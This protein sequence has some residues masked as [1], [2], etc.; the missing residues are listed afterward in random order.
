MTPPA[1]PRRLPWLRPRLSIRS[2]MVLVLLIAAPASWVAYQIRIQREAI[3]TVR[4]AGGTVTF[5]YQRDQVGTNKGGGPVN[6]TEP[7]APRWL[8]RLLGDELFQ[9]VQT[10]RFP[11]PIT[12]TV[13]AAVGR[14]AGLEDLTL[15]EATGAE[16]GFRHL[17]GLGRLERVMIGGPGI[18]D[19]MLDDLAQVAAIR[20]LLLG[21]PQA[22][23]ADGSDITSPATDA[24]FARLAVLLYLEALTIVNFPA[25]T[26]EGAARLLAGLP[27]LRRF[28]LGGVTRASSARLTLE[29]LADHHPGLESL[30]LNYHTGIGEADLQAVGK[31]RN[32]Q[33]LNLAGTGIT[34]A[35][36]AHLRPLKGLTILSFSHTG[37]TDAGLP[38]LGELTSLQSLTL[39]QTKVTDAGII[40]LAPLANLRKLA[41]DADGITD[42][43]MPAVARLGK[44]EDLHLDL[45]PGLTDA[46]LVPLRALAK[47]KVLTV[48]G[49]STTPRGIAALRQAV[50]T[51]TRVNSKPPRPVP[52]PPTAK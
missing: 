10:V 11:K 38:T 25:L 36:L 17:R 37:V 4:A 45:L 6:R 50:P 15:A 52:P 49:T 26:D 7:A 8:R 1:L 22:A 29:A 20:T 31:L 39:N 5:D 34:D 44:L 33:A 41:L 42:A 40:H 48:G 32:L 28:M 21:M 12:P 35:G 24:G 51:L 9:E 16:D 27:L 47:L 46:G 23:V 14:F 19:A 13:L 3:A 2:L 18:T 43:A 30:G